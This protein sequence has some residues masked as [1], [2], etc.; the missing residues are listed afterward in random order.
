MGWY[1]AM[2]VALVPPILV[3]D[4]VARYAVNVPM[5]DHWP[6][7]WI[8]V[9]YFRGELDWAALWYPSGQHRILVPKVVMLSWPI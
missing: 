9:R 4:V 1:V 8:V 2:L 6:F 5:F 7:S 3:L